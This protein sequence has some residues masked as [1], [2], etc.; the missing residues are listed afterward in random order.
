MDTLRQL[1]LATGLF[2]AVSAHAL[3]IDTQVEGP[4]LTTPGVLEFVRQ[5]L[6]G[7]LANAP[8]VEQGGKLRLFVRV[9]SKYVG[10]KGQHLYLAEVQLQRRV[11][12]VETQRLYWAQLRSAVLWGTVPTENEVREAL[13]LLMGEKVSQ[14]KAD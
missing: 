10:P 1:V 4:L 6:Q 3:T 8:D 2:G 14:W 13:G 12:D 11:N 7:E 5:N 9:A